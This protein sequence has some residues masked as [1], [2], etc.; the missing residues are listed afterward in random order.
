MTLIVFINLEHRNFGFCSNFYCF[1]EKFKNLSS[2]WKRPK[3]SLFSKI[4]SFFA[5]NNE[6]RKFK[7]FFSDMNRKQWLLFQQF[8]WNFGS[9]H[10][11]KANFSKDKV[12]LRLRPQYTI[13]FFNEK[14]KRLFLLLLRHSWRHGLVGLEFYWNEFHQ[15]RQL[16]LILTS[17]LQLRILCH[18]RVKYIH[19][20]PIKLLINLR[21]SHTNMKSYNLVT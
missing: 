9:F 12:V 20:R 17:T 19:G 3:F 7:L 16:W 4:W 8:I 21:F 11:I 6:Q 13:F 14:G 15:H 1:F 5:L 2:F 10:Q 18:L